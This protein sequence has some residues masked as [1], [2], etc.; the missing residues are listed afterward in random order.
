VRT[1]QKATPATEFQRSNPSDQVPEAGLA[2][3]ERKHSAALMRVNHTG[4][5][6]AQALYLG[7]S[8]AARDSRLRDSFT[9]A[10]QEEADHLR[11]CAQR[12]AEL[13][14]HTSYL[15]PLWFTG[16]FCMGVAA[17]LIS[18]TWSLGF[19]AQTEY[20]VVQHLSGHLDK[21][22]VEDQKSRA[23]VRQMQEDEAKHET[24]AFEL[25]AQELPEFIKMGM[26]WTAK[27]MTSITYY[28]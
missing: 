24:T 1:L 21:L 5:I 4:E 27:I 2:H 18:D 3:A 19:L 17:G 10:A 23:I 20:Q 28:V 16:S 8:I 13:D 11:W 14:S 9:S 12:I 15:D 25:G 6:C 22:P 26:S 7:Q